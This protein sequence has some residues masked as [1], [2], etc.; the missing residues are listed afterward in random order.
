[1][2]RRVKRAYPSLRAYLDATEQTLDD[3]AQAAGIKKA[4]LC[5]VMRKKR[6]CSFDVALKLSKHANV[7]IESIA[8][9]AQVSALGEK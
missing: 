6:S 8:S 9:E 5:N 1:M 2:P 4:H 7:P 3:L